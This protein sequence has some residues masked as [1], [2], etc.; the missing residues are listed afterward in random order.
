MTVSTKTKFER[1]I[2]TLYESGSRDDYFEYPTSWTGSEAERSENQEGIID[3]YFQPSNY[4]H[5]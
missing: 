3:D 1:K 5:I 4:S 2:K